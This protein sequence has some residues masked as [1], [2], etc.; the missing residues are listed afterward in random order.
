MKKF[1]CFCILF[2]GLL[3]WFGAQSQGVA[4]NN[5]NSSPDASAMLD[6]KS[7]TKGML[8]PRMTQA[9]RNA[10][11]SPATGL[12]IYQTDNNPGLYYNSGT[13]SIPAWFIV[14]NNAGQW[15]N[16]GSIIYYNLGKVGI[17]TSSPVSNFHVA[18]N[19]P[20][21]TGSFGTPVNA[22]T[23]GTNVAIGDDNQDAVLYVGQSP[24]NKGFAL[25]R[26]HTVL[27]DAFF[28]LGTYDGLN[29]LILQEV[30]G[31]VGVRTTSPAALFHV[32]EESPGLTG[33]FGRPINNWNSSTN[34]SIGDDNGPAVMYIGQSEANTGLLSWQY[35]ATP[36]N[37]YF[38]IAT[39]SGSNPLVLQGDAAAGGKVGIGTTSPAALFHVAEASPGYT[40]LFGSN[41]TGYSGGTNVSIGDDNASSLLYVGQSSFNKGFMLWTYDATPSNAHLG[42]GTYNGSNPLILQEAGGNVGIG[43]IYPNS[44]L[45]VDYN[46]YGQSSLGYN[47]INPMYLYHMEIVADG[48][49]QSNL[50]G[51]RTREAQND[52]TGYSYYSSNCA[53]K[54]YSFWGDLYSFGTSGFNYMDYTRCGGVLGAEQGGYVWGSLGYKTSGSAYYGGYFTSYTSGTG[55]DSQANIGIGI[56]AWGDLIGADIHGKVYGIYAEG[57]NYAMFSNGPIYRNNLDIHLQD[58]GTGTNT[59][60]YTNVSTDATIQTCGV[61]TLSNGTK[62]IA[63]DQ[64]FSA[65]VSSESPVIVTVTPIGNSNG[66]YL[67]EVSG[68]GFTVVENNGGKSNITV[69]YIAI[70]KRAG[71]ENPSLPKE[72]IDA[73]YTKNMARG[74]HNDADTQTN[75]EGL[76][77]EN[78]QLVVGIHP[79]TLPNLNKPAEETV[80]PKPSTPP[81]TGVA[82]NFSPTGFGE[83]GQVQQQVPLKEIPTVNSPSG[84]KITNQPIQQSRP[85]ID[86]SGAASSKSEQSTIPLNGDRSNDGTTPN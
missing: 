38:N 15:L 85:A 45:Q 49:G 16:N 34:V 61:A 58:N 10:I 29:N 24:S 2:V 43:T 79:S 65:A 66:V 28:S 32:A 31:K 14:G 57:E 8:A 73:G 33:V 13:P 78:G 23:G 25:W 5:D 6:V 77:Y 12:T 59:V 7:L 21:F 11:V 54:G 82:N 67:S 1:I 39:Y 53:L 27:S 62:S 41:I 51:F 22:Y 50:Y 37:A 46:S 17:G 55:K 42:I 60:L 75:G 63:F 19:G 72:V 52:G 68:N 84:G 83:P 9:Q 71:Y 76:Y 86:K 70:G 26:Y 30:G 20:G 44:R 74:L 81:K 64:T 3:A 56:G 69:N 18:E 80:L 40:G 48:D 36:S 47:S 35:S 4:I